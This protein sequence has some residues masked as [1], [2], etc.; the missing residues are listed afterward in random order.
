MIINENSRA[1]VVRDLPE[2]G[3]SAGDVGV[4]V[5]IHLNADKEPVGYMLE[6]FNI[7]G[8]SID[9]VSIGFEDVR[10]AMPTD[11]MLARDAA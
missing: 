5:H 4:V 7:D 9:V 10:S 11:R 3:L 2:V 1:V 8:E 6:T